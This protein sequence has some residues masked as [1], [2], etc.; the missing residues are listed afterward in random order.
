VHTYRLRYLL[1]GSTERYCYSTLVPFALGTIVLR[2]L[3]PMQQ[4]LNSVDGHAWIISL[5]YLTWVHISA[6][7]SIVLT[8]RLL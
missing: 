3:P 6:G 4:A 2:A 8:T 7:T 5:Q 1:V